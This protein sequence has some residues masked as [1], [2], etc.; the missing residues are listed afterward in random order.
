ME[1]NGKEISPELMERAT[2][3]RTT[4]ELLA[5]AKENG[6]ELTAEQAEA[7][8]AVYQS[9]KISDNEL[10]AVAGG[11]LMDCSCRFKQNCDSRKRGCFL[12][13]AVCEYLGKADDCTELTTLRAYRDNWLANE[14]G[15]KEL[16]E[17]YY[18]IA[19]GIVRAMKSSADYGE[20]CEELL[21]R[22]IRPC[23]ALIAEGKNEECKEL[24]MEMVRY[25]EGIA[26]GLRPQSIAV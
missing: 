1:I 25:A 13:T 16:I 14:P 24:Y 26:T 22:Y 17:E 19:P 12:T 23:L 3:C 15:G 6:I 10:D 5:L 11:N 21:T 20:L 4:E 9:G 7:Y 18:R 8:L 2:K